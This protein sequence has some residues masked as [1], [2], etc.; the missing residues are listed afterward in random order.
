[1]FS[2]CGTICLTFCA[3]GDRIAPTH[4]TKFGGMALMPLVRIQ[5]KENSSTIENSRQL[6]E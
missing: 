1:M 6:P 2:R 4:K 5:E 3:L